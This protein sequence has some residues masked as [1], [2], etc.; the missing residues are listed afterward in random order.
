MTSKQLATISLSPQAW[1][2]E[3]DNFFLALNKDDP[4]KDFPQVIYDRLSQPGRAPNASLSRAFVNL[5]K[6]VRAGTMEIPNVE[7][8]GISSIT[9]SGDI[10]I[11]GSGGMVPVLQTA[12]SPTIPSTSNGSKTSNTGGL[13]EV[14]Y[15]T[16]EE[17]KNKGTE[18]ILNAKRSLQYPNHSSDDVPVYNGPWNEDYLK[19][20]NVLEN[21][22]N[23]EN[24]P[25]VQETGSKKAAET[26]NLTSEHWKMVNKEFPMAH[27]HGVAVALYHSRMNVLEQMSSLEQNNE[28]LQNNNALL[29]QM[30]QSLTTRLDQLEN[31]KPPATIPTKKRSKW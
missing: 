23:L 20:D 13:S 25:F 8:K 24:F 18:P 22:K 4:N 7:K 17:T 30:V 11:E 21:M 27:L 3:I 5:V 15:V 9:S 10:S 6:G 1:K 26:Y 12:G 28:V 16:P 2:V 31:T 29:F 19:K 14:L